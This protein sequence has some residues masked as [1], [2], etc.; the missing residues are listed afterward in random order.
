MS[1]YSFLDGNEEEIKLPLNS[2]IKESQSSELTFSH[3]IES[4]EMPGDP[5]SNHR[6]NNMNCS[7]LEKMISKMIKEQNQTSD[8]LNRYLPK[9]RVEVWKNVDIKLVVSRTA[10]G[11]TIG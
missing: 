3:A 6:G 1:T 2:K 9:S 10:L 11:K 8:L 7:K 4:H 5:K